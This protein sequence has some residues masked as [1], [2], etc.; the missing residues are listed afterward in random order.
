MSSHALAQDRARDVHFDYAVFT[1]LTRDHLDYHGSFAAYGAAKSKLFTDWELQAAVI[2]VADPFGQSLVERIQ[3]PV[4][5]Y[6]EGGDWSWQSEPHGIGLQVSWT[7]PDGVFVA[8]LESMA[9]Y[10]VANITAAMATLVA[11]GVSTQAVFEQVSQLRGVP[12]RLERVGASPTHPKV[13]VDYAHTPDALAKVLASLR[14]FCEGQ[15]MCVVG[16]GGDRDSGKRPLMGAVAATGAD[17]VWLTSDNPRSEEPGQIIA[18]MRAGAVGENPGLAT[19]IIECVDR[20]AAIR[21]ALTAA[22]PKDVVLIAGKGH[23]N[24]QEIA[25]KKYPFDD[26]L[27]VTQI[28]EE[29][30]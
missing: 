16:C 13:V 3:F 15:L 23:E 7:T 11:T 22:T 20:A 28:L 9:D 14:P 1:N 21:A 6:G 29:L 25:G 26:R 19:K 30:H 12:G 27:V 2:N 4:V 5:T 18:Q 10:A 24:Y 17:V 8:H